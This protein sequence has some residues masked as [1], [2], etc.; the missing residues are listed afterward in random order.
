MSRF[1]MVIANNYSSKPGR[2]AGL[3]ASLAS[4]LTRDCGDRGAVHRITEG[5]EVP[6]KTNASQ[7]KQDR[8]MGI[9]WEWY[10]QGAGRED[11]E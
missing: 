9:Q 5:S 1:A 2:N 11:A 10:S 4:G 3:L 6:L 7:S 8:A